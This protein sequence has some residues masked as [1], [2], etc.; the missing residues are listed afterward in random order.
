MT[1]TKL[2]TYLQDKQ[3]FAKHQKVL[4]AVS[5]GKDSMNLLYFLYAYRDI[6]DI[7]LGIAHVNHHQRPEASV[8]EDYIR[9]W[10]KEHSIALYVGHFEGK[11][12]E[13]RARDFRYAFFKE[14]MSKYHYSALVTAHHADD[15]AETVLMR[16]IRGSRLRHLS[17]IKEV[18][19]FGSGELIRPF[20]H[21]SKSDLLD[22]EHFED[23]SNAS[24]NYFRNRVRNSY[25]PSLSKENPQLKKALTYLA[26]DIETIYQAFDDV[27]ADKDMTQVTVFHQ[28][29]LSVQEVSLQKYLTAFPELDL[30]RAQFKIMLDLL[31]RRSHLSYEIKLGY[32]LYKDDKHFWIEKALTSPQEDET[33]CLLYGEEGYYGEYQFTFLEQSDRF[34]PLYSRSKIYLRRRQDGDKLFLGAF[35]KKISRLFIDDKLPQFERQ[36]AIIGEQD[37]QIIFVVTKRKTYLRKA[38]KHDIMLGKLYYKSMK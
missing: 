17:G 15:Q 12:T 25:L 3:L 19:S 21:L 32:V 31:R 28:Q 11:F 8:E 33:L 6:L 24:E 29:T 20:L 18:Q 34:V 9:Q 4:V 30:S 2:L 37:G 26:R 35:H 7:E 22:V 36:N 23:S 13:K 27:T 38:Y 10:A 14:I 5:T 16:I 1:D